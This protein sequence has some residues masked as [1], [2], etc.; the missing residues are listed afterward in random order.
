MQLEDGKNDIV[1]VVKPVESVES[2]EAIESVEAVKL[3]DDYVSYSKT[4]KSKGR[5]KLALK[6]KII[7]IHAF[8]KRCDYDRILEEYDTKNMGIED[9]GSYTSIGRFLGECILAGFEVIKKN[10][11]NKGK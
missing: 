5:H 6:N 2:V 4:R 11:E 10:K 7:D 9:D 3:V 1:E 8:I